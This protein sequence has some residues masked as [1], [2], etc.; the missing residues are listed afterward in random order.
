M[1]QLDFNTTLPQIFWLIIT[2]FFVYMLLIH[3]FL[4]NFIKFVKSR[5]LLI[6]VN[7]KKCSNLQKQLTVKQLTVKQLIHK[8]FSK[9]KS[10]LEKDFSIFFMSASSFN[11]L[12]SDKKI[13]Y[14]I[15][16]NIMYYDTIILNSIPLRVTF[17]N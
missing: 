17:L 12:F 5:K 4:P 6:L 10:I 9:I 7:T 2:F 11:F 16:H 3:F 14:T 15:Y 8:N 1:P 13:A